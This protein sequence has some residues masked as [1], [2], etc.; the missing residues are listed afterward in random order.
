MNE[1][2]LK[3]W[4]KQEIARQVAVITSGQSGEN[5]DVQSEDIEN[6]YPGSPTIPKRPLMHPYGFASR[7][8]KGV[9]QVTA[10][11]GEGPTN[12]MILGHRAKDRPADIEEGESL[13]YS[14]AGY[15]I[16]A[17]KDGIRIHK[18]SEKYS[19]LLGEDVITFIA[20]LVDL[21]VAHTHGPPGTPPTNAGDFTQLKTNDLASTTLLSTEDGGF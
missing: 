17:H 14:E 8:P 21:I 12:R 6:L 18:G 4:V 10:K 3:R 19:L 13:I 20:A 9:I 11:V 7:A 16:V 2:E 5:A 15:K 1:A